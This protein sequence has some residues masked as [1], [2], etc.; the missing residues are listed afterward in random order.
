MLIN[1]LT[2]EG[3]LVSKMRIQEFRFQFYLLD[4]R[5]RII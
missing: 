3:R 5:G 1:K 4:S 2:T